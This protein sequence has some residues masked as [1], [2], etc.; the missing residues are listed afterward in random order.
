MAR[1]PPA[2]ALN[3]NGLHI[4]NIAHGIYPHRRLSQRELTRLVA[5]LN[6]RAESFVGNGRRYQGG[7]EKFEPREMEDLLISPGPPTDASA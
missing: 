4:L 2:F 5:S 3:P 7:L 6:E 1:R